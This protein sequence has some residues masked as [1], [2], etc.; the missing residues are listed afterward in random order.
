[1]SRIA[2]LTAAAALAGLA[3]A[4]VAAQYNQYPQQQYP[5][6]YPQQQYPQQQYPEPY[7]TPPGYGYDQQYTP[8][9]GAGALGTIVDSLI[10]NR[11]DVSYRQAIRQCAFAAVQRARYQYSGGYRDWNDFV[12]VT[13]ITDVQ[14]RTLVIRVKGML[15]LGRWHGYGNGYGSG[16][17]TGGGRR[18]IGFRCDVDYN[19]YVRN[20]RLD[21]PYGGY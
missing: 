7:Q 14:R 2:S 11:Y 18:N 8:D 17:P 12:H 20:V 5:Q 9:Q 4:P 21:N 1:M 16:Y 15:G 3:A 6:Q 13:G 19:G 10:G